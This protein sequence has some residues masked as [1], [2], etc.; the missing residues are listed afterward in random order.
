MATA[1]AR[2]AR[3][4]RELRGAIRAADTTGDSGDE[5]H[6]ATIDT[7]MHYHV[8][9]PDSGAPGL[10]SD[11]GHVHRHSHGKQP[12]ANSP[13][14]PDNDH[15]GAGHDHDPAD[16]PPGSFPDPGT[17][18]D[19]PGQAA[20]GGRQLRAAADPDTHGPGRVIHRHRHRHLDGTWHSELHNHDDEE[21]QAHVTA[22]ASAARQHA[23]AVTQTRKGSV[24]E[25]AMEEYQVSGKA[26][27]LAAAG[28]GD[29]AWERLV[30]SAAGL[31]NRR[32]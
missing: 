24:W 10:D 8:H 9:G 12:D 29:A 19:R 22:A 13:L 6:A 2:E 3:Q 28:S 16:W 17:A 18:G 26:R 27:V 5:G 32:G 23:T 31:Q 15:D 7:H 25:K 30:R 21:H 1:A 4:L 14:H 11:G 20:R